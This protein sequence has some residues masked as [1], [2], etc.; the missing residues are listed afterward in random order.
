M[1][2]EH[3]PRT[4]ALPPEVLYRY[5]VE[6]RLVFRGT[7]RAQSGRRLTSFRRPSLAGDW[8]CDLPSPPR[9][10]R[11]ARNHS[12]DSITADAFECVGCQSSSRSAFETSNHNDSPKSSQWYGANGTSDDCPSACIAT[13][14][15]FAG[16]DTTCEPVFA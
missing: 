5:K 1:S 3:R 9:D 13:C 2:T 10:S 14:A 15:G 6:V 16:N 4:D 7:L 8:W 12:Y 11:C